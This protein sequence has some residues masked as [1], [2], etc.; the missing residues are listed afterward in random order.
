VE[1]RKGHEDYFGMVA[2]RYFS[3]LVN[4]NMPEWEISNMIAKYYITTTALEMA[5]KKR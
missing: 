1:Q 4:R 5:K 2:Q 3:F